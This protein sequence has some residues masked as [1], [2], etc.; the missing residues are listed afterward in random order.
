MNKGKKKKTVKNMVGINSTISVITLNVGA[1][2]A[3]FK[4]KIY[5]VR[6]TRP[7]YMLCMRSPLQIE[8]HICI[9]SKWMEKI[10]YL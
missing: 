7:N 9:K 2:Y 8:R 4:R 6:N 10:G 1:P 5:S 3:P